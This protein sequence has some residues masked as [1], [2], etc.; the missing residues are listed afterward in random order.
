MHACWHHPQL[1]RGIPLS[2]VLPCLCVQV[3][4]RV[5]AP[6]AEAV[7]PLPGGSRQGAGKH[8]TEAAWLAAADAAAACAALCCA[9]PANCAASR[10]ATLHAGN[11]RS[12][13]PASPLPLQFSSSKRLPGGEAGAEALAAALDLG[14]A[15]MLHHL[16]LE[17]LRDP[18]LLPQPTE[19]PDALQRVGCTGGAR[20]LQGA[21]VQGA[22]E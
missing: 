16:C 8:K 22:Q 17:S 5:F 6:P 12:L 19:V 20:V 21:R 4:R 13:F 3:W 18:A 2:P 11:T 7:C 9:I 14:G 10:P 1:Y 15:L